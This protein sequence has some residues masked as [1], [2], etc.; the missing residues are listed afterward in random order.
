MSKTQID[1]PAGVP[2]V[3]ITR[4]FDA[5][6]ELVR[7]AWTDPDLVKQWLGP[8]K[9]EMVIE[10][11]EP[12]AGGAYRYIHRDE[13]GNEF[14][15]HGVFHSSD[16]DNMVQTF[17]FEGVPGHVSLDK[18]AL[19]DIGGGRTRARIHSVYQSLEDR[20]GMVQSGMGDGVNEGFERLDELLATM[21]L[22]VG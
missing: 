1:A 12:R 2:F 21:P 4:E 22:P 11:W 18:L 17:E 9:Y 7:R 3:D 6:L 19:E 10:R 16:P 14:G 20:D 13:A 5:P 15:F 8:R